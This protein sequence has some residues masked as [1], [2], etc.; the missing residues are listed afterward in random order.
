M[1]CM[2][3]NYG[4]FV[5]SNRVP[6]GALF[7][8]NLTNQ[9]GLPDMLVRAIEQSWYSGE[10]EKRFTS[11]TQLLKPTKQLILEKRHA[12]AL[13]QDASD[14][15]WSLMGSAMRKVIEAAEDVNSLSEERLRV[16]IDGAVITGGIDFYEDGVISDFKFTGVWNHGRVSRIAEWEKQ[17]NM[18][19][20]LYQQHGF[21]VEKLQVVAI[22][23]DWNRARWEKDTDYPEQ[24]ETIDIPL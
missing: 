21:P 11:V 18:Y 3:F 10:G 16:E 13:K 14:M 19:A 4:K 5:N 12:K 22:Y 17:L 9:R 6:H 23:R 24:V 15:I 7:V 2:V 8:M 20:Y 1:Y